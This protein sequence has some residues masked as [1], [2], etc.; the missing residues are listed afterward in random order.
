MNNKFENLNQNAQ[1]DFVLKYF[2][3]I[4]RRQQEEAQL[5]KLE[6]LQRYLMIKGDS[7]SELNGKLLISKSAY[8]RYLKIVE[9]IYIIRFKSEETDYISRSS[10]EPLY[11]KLNIPKLHEKKYGYELS[12]EI[13]SRFDKDIIEEIWEQVNLDSFWD[14]M[15]IDAQ[16]EQEKRVKFTAH[17]LQKSG[18]LGVVFQTLTNIINDNFE[19]E[20]VDNGILTHTNFNLV[21]IHDSRVFK[22]NGNLFLGE[23]EKELK[24]RY[25]KMKDAEEEFD[26]GL[27]SHYTPPFERFDFFDEA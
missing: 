27:E 2:P 14:N 24:R 6:F 3:L 22:N 10:I 1:K 18:L 4:F 7:K 21:N 19:T 11:S 5:S 15:I 8:K 13:L 9:N 26:R 12:A 25:I 23:L 16:K 17:L 20:E